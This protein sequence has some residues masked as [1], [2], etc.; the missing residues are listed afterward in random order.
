M[1]LKL[2]HKPKPLVEVQ[3]DRA[4]GT[5]LC[6]DGDD[7]F[8]IGFVEMIKTE[9]RDGVNWGVNEMIEIP[10]GDHHLDTFILETP[11]GCFR[12]PFYVQGRPG[13]ILILT[14]AGGGPGWERC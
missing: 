5:Y 6:K 10:L 3:A 8:D 12:A 4:L 11:H 13:D 14:F 1:K 9:T 7:I 2:R